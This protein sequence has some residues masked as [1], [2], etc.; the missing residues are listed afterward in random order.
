MNC[1]MF[2]LNC[3]YRCDEN[4]QMLHTSESYFVEHQVRKDTRLSP[5]YTYSHL[6][7]ESLGTRLRLSSVGLLCKNTTKLTVLLL[8]N[9]HVAQWNHNREHQQRNY[10]NRHT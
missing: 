3:S 1:V 8:S 2:A 9:R 4:L 5:A 7:R 6:E 10:P